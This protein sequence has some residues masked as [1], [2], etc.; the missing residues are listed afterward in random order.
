MSRNPTFN[1]PKFLKGLNEGTD[2]KYVQLPTNPPGILELVLSR[3]AML[4]LCA[5]SGS[6]AGLELALAINRAFPKR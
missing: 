1:L 5:S 6:S 2:Y 3:A 4:K